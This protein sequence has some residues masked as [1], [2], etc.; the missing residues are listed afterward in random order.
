VERILAAAVRVMERVAPDEPRVSDIVT[1]AGSPNKAF[2]RYFAGKDELI[3]AV[4]EREVAIVVSYLQHQM[5][6]ESRAL[7][8]GSGHGI[9][10]YAASGSVA[11]VRVLS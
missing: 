10:G 1:E 9:C 5:A 3:L 4:M 8:P 7:T 11:G 2:Y 6:K